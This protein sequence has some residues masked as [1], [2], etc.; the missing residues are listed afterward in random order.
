VLNEI[1]AVLQRKDHRTR[2]ADA[3]NRRM[4]ETGEAVTCLRPKGQILDAD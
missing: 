4:R 3:R 2:V 1:A